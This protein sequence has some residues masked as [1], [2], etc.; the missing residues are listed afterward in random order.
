MTIPDNLAAFIFAR[1]GSK[2]VPNKNIKLLNG[3]PLISYS[4]EQ[5][6]SSEYINKVIVSTDS[7]EIASIAKEYGAAVPFIRPEELATDTSP[8]WQAWRHAI[9]RY[10]QSNNEPLDLLI[11]VPCTSP[12]RDSKDIDCCI[13]EYFITSPDAVITGTESQRNPY[14]NMVKKVSDGSV[15]KI[16]NDHNI[17]RRQ[18]A[19]KVYDMTTVCYVVS[20]NYILKHDS[21][22]QA[23]QRL[24]EVPYP[25][26]L[27]IDTTDDFELAE[28]YINKSKALSQCEA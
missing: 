13:E 4:I 24:I 20:A 11:S 16:L 7:V 17:T 28:Y 27:D 22:N 18:D 5:A 10:N 6:L 1:G 23:Q 8:E 19:P 26:C 15:E 21:F 25:R 3:K 14:F 9:E 2:G 12:L